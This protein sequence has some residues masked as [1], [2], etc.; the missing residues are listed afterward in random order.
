MSKPMAENNFE[1]IF[2]NCMQKITQQKVLNVDQQ[3]WDEQ[4]I[5]DYFKYSLDYTKKNIICNPYFPPSRDLPTSP[6]G[7]R[8]AKRWK[9]K[10]IIDFGMAFDKPSLKFKKQ[11]I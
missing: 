10:D 9:A 5:A 7:D 8:I 2:I 6:T 11:S 1:K 3:L 4:D